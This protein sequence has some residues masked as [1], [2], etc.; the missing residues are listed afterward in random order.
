ML[1]VCFWEG[2][3]NRENNCNRKATGFELFTKIDA[4]AIEAIG[5]HSRSA[6][7]QKSFQFNS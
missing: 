5:R 3:P 1:N 6:Y 2:T 4:A 7:W